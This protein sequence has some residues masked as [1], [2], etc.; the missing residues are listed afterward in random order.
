LLGIP[1]TCKELIGCRGLNFSTGLVLRKDLKA[2]H[3]AYVVRLM[4]ESGAILTCVTI[5]SELGLWLESSNYVYGKSKNPYDTRR[6][7]GGS[8]GGEAALISACGSL[9]GVGNDIAG[10]I[11]MPAFF[12][13]IYG[14]KPT[15]G[16]FDLFQR[17]TIEKNNQ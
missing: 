16:K 6:M 4:K 17:A 5:T 14:H 7:T 8:S 10:S 1:F 9:I 12:N 11:R 13:G 15:N 3:D 2:E